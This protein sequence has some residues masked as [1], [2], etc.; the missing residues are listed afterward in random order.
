MWHACPVADFD[1]IAW[2]PLVLGLSGIGAALSWAAWK[3]RDLAA[4]LRGFGWSLLPVAAY[5]T[6][7][8]ELIWEVASSL[9]DWAVHLVFSPTVWLGMVVGGVAVVCIVVSGLLRRRRPA[10]A[11]T[12]VASGPRRSARASATGS[13]SAPGQ[14]KPVSRTR[15][16][17]TASVDSEFAEIEQ[18]LKNRGIS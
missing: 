6:G 17:P 18:I 3:R 11:D 16:Q 7:L 1:Q 10:G 14:P 5:L 4:G 8:L 13:T 15:S 12:E 9:I 2:L